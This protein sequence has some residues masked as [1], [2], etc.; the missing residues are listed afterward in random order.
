MYSELYF[1]LYSGQFRDCIVDCIVDCILDCKVD[2]IFATVGK[3]VLSL[4]LVN[5]IVCCGQSVF[6]FLYRNYPYSVLQM[7]DARLCVTVTLSYQPT[8]CQNADAKN[9]N[10]PCSQKRD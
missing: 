9:I 7:E 10:I 5:Y 6:V 8:R 1:G 2:C 3:I 4:I